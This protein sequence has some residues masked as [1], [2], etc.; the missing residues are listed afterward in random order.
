MLFR[1]V[2]HAK[3]REESDALEII[4]LRRKSWFMILGAVFSILFWGFF[5]ISFF[6]GTPAVPISR[7]S[8]VYRPIDSQSS[9][10]IGSFFGI[11][12]LFYVYFILAIVFG[13]ETVRVSR[14][15]VLITARILF[16]ETKREYTYL[17]T[18]RL[19][20]LQISEG[21]YSSGS[22]PSLAFDYG[23]R[24]IRFGRGID[25]AEAAQ[26]LERVVTKFPQYR[27][28]SAIGSA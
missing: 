23:S 19:R 14:N 6:Q 21:S 15:S 12:A 28:N 25:E 13:V 11:I 24:T 3:V 18:S 2:S 20:N 26:I 7:G 10:L 4:I 27:S 9:L 22:T 1:S 5:A 8:D 17:H 16:F